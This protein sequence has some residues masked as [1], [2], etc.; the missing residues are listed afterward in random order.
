MT[1]PAIRY[2][3]E[4]NPVP[5]VG[6]D[7]PPRG[8][9]AGKPIPD[10]GADPGP[11]PLVILMPVDI[12]HV[13]LSLGASVAVIWLLKNAQDVLIPFVVSGLL[14]YALDPFVDRLQRWHVPRAIGALVMLLAVVGAVGS[15][16]YYLSDQ[17]V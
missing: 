1:P 3:A 10:N 5:R 12:R 9:V 13:A 16:G 8:D 2:S 17:F 4:G 14:F 11:A 6:G 7:E 15:T